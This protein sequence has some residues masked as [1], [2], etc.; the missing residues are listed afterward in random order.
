VQK[1]QFPGSRVYK[2]DET[3][4]P[5]VQTPSKIPESKEQKKKN[6]FSRKLGKR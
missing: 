1:N 6:R 4:T 2:M 3:G 5:V